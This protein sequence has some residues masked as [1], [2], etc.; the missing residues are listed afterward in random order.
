[1]GASNRMGIKRIMIDIG[2]K[3]P[4]KQLYSIAETKN[5]ANFEYFLFLHFLGVFFTSGI[6][7]FETA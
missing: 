3:C 7:E 4:Y 2:K 6:S 5:Y 1:M